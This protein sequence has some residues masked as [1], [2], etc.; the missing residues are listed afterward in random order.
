M[1]HSARLSMQVD[2]TLVS[3]TDSSFIGFFST[4]DRHTRS[5]I[6]SLPIAC[7][8]VIKFCHFRTLLAHICSLLWPLIVLSRASCARQP[9]VSPHCRQLRSTPVSVQLYGHRTISTAT[10]S[11][12]RSAL[13]A[14][15]IRGWIDILSA[16]STDLS[17]VPANELAGHRYRARLDHRPRRIMPGSRQNTLLQHP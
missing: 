9:D 6:K 8:A 15:L 12:Y 2:A 16:H 3:V 13:A 4:V 1:L 17:C 7:P 14:R 5:S 10:P 11:D